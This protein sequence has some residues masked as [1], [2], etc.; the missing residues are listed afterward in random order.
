MRQET[1]GP[2]V[3]GTVAGHG[4]VAVGADVLQDAEARTVVEPAAA[5]PG[6]DLI[7]LDGAGEVPVED[8]LVESARGPA[9][10]APHPAAGVGTPGFSRASGAAGHARHPV[11][12]GQQGVQPHVHVRLVPRQSQ[13]LEG[14]RGDLHR[15][16]VGDAAGRQ[17]R[18]DVSGGRHQHRPVHPVVGQPV[19]PGG[20]EALVPARFQ[21]GGTL[22]E[23][24]V[25]EAAVPAGAGPGPAG[26]KRVGPALPG[27]CRQAGDLPGHGEEDRPVSGTRGQGPAD[28]LLQRVDA[29]AVA[30]EGGQDRGRHLRR[31]GGP[32]Q[33]G[34][35]H[36][37][38]ADLDERAA[39]R[40]QCR[41]GGLGEQHGA[42]QVAPPVPGVQPRALIALPQ[43]AGHGGGERQAQRAGAQ[44]GQCLLQRRGEG[45]HLPAVE[46]VVE[47]QQAEED[48]L[49]RQLAAQ[50][51]QR[52]LLTADGDVPDAVDGRDLQ[53]PA[54]RQEQRAGLPL[55]Q[56]DGRHAA[57]ADG[58]GLQPA[59]FGHHP[60]GGR[61]VQGTGDA[62]GG[63]LPDAV[64]EDRVGA[65]PVRVERG[66]QSQL[67]REQ[68]GL[69]DL[70]AVHARGLARLGEFPRHR[71]A[72]Q[73]CQRRVGLLDGGPERG[74]LGHEVGSH[75]VPLGAVAGEGEHDG[76][77]RGPVGDGRGRH[78]QG[79][80]PL[81]QPVGGLLRAARQDHGAVRG[82]VPAAA[83][84]VGGVVEV[85]RCDR[86]Q[87]VGHPL[88]GDR[89]DVLGAGRDQHGQRRARGPSAGALRHRVDGRGCE[90]DVGVGPAETGGADPDHAAPLAGRQR[91]GGDRRFQPER[92]EVDGRGE[93]FG[94]Q[95]GGDPAVA[96]HQAGLEQGGHARGRLQV[97]QVALD[98]PDG[99]RP[100]GACRAQ[101]PADGLALG[102]VAGLGAGA[103]GLEVDQFVG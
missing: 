91:P 71:P 96:Q 40:R 64:S 60:G 57:A 73:R 83:R 31:L 101:S 32:A 49:A 47:I 3:I 4:L 50:L 86:L 35:E 15:R 37:V 81:P 2:E 12:V 55:R 7:R 34:G 13:R 89:E 69:G 9:E 85:V 43:R 52:A 63:E 14:E 56:A 88:D 72:E 10:Q 92:G 33:V 46:G 74:H 23:Q 78:R 58:G 48:V 24:R 20:V 54:E 1:R 61:H 8:L 45:V 76:A 11:L 75:A 82:D 93:R 87:V 79:G 68:G 97:S 19:Q 5:G 90:H 70:G 30:V 65:H 66:D 26:R 77:V 100:P 59:A 36:R 29:R 17:E 16:V 25:V 67:E 84:G 41:G 42:P 21:G 80:G 103:V 53:L 95:G 99:Q 6:V 18:L 102:A 62:G 39:S 98:R 22:A 28:G 94:V 38:R 44:I 51:L 27:V